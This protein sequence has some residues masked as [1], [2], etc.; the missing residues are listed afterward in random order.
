[1]KIE[2]R[3]RVSRSFDLLLHSIHHRLTFTNPFAS[4]TF[5]KDDSHPSLAEQ[6]LWRTPHKVHPRLG[7]Q[8]MHHDFQRLPPQDRRRAPDQSSR[9]YLPTNATP[10]THYNFYSYC[11]DNQLIVPCVRITVAR[12]F[13]IRSTDSNVWNVGKSRCFTAWED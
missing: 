5:N 3:K 1:M 11:Y 12:W 10:P 2:G 6:A 7:R 8:P 13:L 4:N 9:T